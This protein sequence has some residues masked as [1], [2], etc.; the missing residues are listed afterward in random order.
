MYARE[1]KNPTFDVEAKNFAS[2]WKRSLAYTNM[3][4]FKDISKEIRV[5]KSN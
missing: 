4:K 5:F 2:W 3:S 1:G